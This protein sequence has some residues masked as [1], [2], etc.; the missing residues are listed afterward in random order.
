MFAVI[1]TPQSREKSAWNGI[2]HLQLFKDFTNRN[3]HH[4]ASI[5]PTLPQALC[6]SDVYLS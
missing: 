2:L 5:V 3:C 1:Y 4:I 6:Y